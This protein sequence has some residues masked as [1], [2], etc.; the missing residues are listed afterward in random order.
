M[1]KY[2]QDFYNQLNRYQKIKL[3]LII[4]MQV[5]AYQHGIAWQKE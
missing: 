1:N 2:F 3:V 5:K 4:E